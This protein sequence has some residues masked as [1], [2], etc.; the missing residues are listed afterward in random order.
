M[1][2]LAWRWTWTWTWTWLRIDRSKRPSEMT[3]C[4]AHNQQHAR[5]SPRMYICFTCKM[6]AQSSDRHRAPIMAELALWVGCQPLAWIS[7]AA[8]RWYSRSSRL[9]KVLFRIKKSWEN[10]QQQ[11]LLWTNN[12][13]WKNV[14]KCSASSKATDKIEVR[15]QQ[16]LPYRRGFESRSWNNT[17]IVQILLYILYHG[18]YVV[19]NQKHGGKLQR[20]RILHLQDVCFEPISWKKIMQ[21]N[22]RS[23]QFP[24]KGTEQN[25]RAQILCTG[26]ALF[27]IQKH[28]TTSAE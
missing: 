13:A 17:A 26:T 23:R 11:L 20:V 6:P 19:W 7:A 10:T 8:L 3:T 5:R 15:M 18:R 24:I 21:Y 2:H 25:C 12:S 22:N 27:P 4:L 28:A 9:E 1:H 16:A 14:R